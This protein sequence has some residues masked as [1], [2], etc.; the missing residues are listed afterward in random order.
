VPQKD[1]CLLS[2][3]QA[4]QTLDFCFPELLFHNKKFSE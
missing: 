2:D 3:E 1:V 4:Q